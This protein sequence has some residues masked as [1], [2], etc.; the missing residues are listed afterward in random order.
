[1]SA[2]S[3]VRDFCAAVAK[4]DIPALGE[5]FADESDGQYLS[6]KIPDEIR[7]SAAL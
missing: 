2:E 7:A 5:F 4:L 3:I 6:R 1:M